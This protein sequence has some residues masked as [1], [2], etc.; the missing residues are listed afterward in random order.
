V[1]ATAYCSVLGG[2]VIENLD[3]F[4][5]C[6]AGE[7]TF[8]WHERHRKFCHLTPRPLGTMAGVGIGSG[9]SVA[10][11]PLD[12]LLIADAMGDAHAYAVD[13]LRFMEKDIHEQLA[14]PLPPCSHSGCDNLVVPGES[15]CA[16]HCS[17]PLAELAD[18][19]A[20]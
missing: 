12:S 17:P 8:F 14:V 7:G 13:V 5:Q 18:W 4:L 10:D 20:S 19:R 6:A 3:Q 16:L 1:W 11:E 2:G 15:L 9:G